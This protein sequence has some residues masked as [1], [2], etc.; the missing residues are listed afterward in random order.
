MELS[1][2]HP[3][4]SQVICEALGRDPETLPLSARLINDLGAESIDYL[5]ILF[6]LER[7]FAVKIPRGQITRQARGDLSEE[8]FQQGGVVSPVGLERLRS[9]LTEVPA[10]GIRTGLKVGEIP[11]LFTVETFCK[12][13]LRALEEKSQAA[14]AAGDSR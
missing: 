10:D 2:V 1:E 5:D 9:Y 4:V 3:K 13:V 7:A 6:R 11:A 14:G 8:E 12:L